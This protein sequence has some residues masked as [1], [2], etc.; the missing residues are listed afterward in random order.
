MSRLRR[1]AQLAAP[2]SGRVRPPS[3]R[4][5][6][7]R[8][9]TLAM[10]QRPLT[11]ERAVKR[12]AELLDAAEPLFLDLD[13]DDVS[14]DDVAEAAGVSHGLI[15]QYFG[16][17]KGLYLAGLER[18]VAQ[19]R[20]RVEP[21]EGMTGTDALIGSLTRYLDWA[22]EH[23]NGY[24]S[25]MAGGGGFAEARAMVDAAREAGIARIA[26]GLG[27][28]LEDD[29]GLR[30]A[31]RGWTG[32]NERSILAWIEDPDAVP[33]D[34]V[35]GGIVAALGAVLAARGLVPPG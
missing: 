21:P 17:K 29:P 19:F 30:I 23:P 31:L 15:F 10:A 14:M 8:S 34:E 20:E 11:T 16:S 5:R 27:R 1:A 12:R 32:L 2:C 4:I 13:Y 6:A 22:A 7:C 26:Q 25:L 24:R 33:R 9:Y 28:N 3:R 35:I 18:I